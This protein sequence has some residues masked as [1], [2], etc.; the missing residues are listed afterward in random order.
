MSSFYS[1]VRDELVGGGGDPTAAKT[2]AGAT[3]SDN[4]SS[5]SKV[6]L[7]TSI[8]GVGVIVALLAWLGSN[9]I[10]T[11]VFV[12]GLIISVFLHEVGH[13]VTARRTGMKVTQFYMGFGPRLLAWR[14][15][16]VE[17]GL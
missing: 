17:Y 8:L 2:R 4:T 14:R 5:E 3:P 11:L 16:E 7:S 1:R 12:L 10:W 9:N 15:G 13:F 6:P